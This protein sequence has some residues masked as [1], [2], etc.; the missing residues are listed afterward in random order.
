MVSADRTRAQLSV[1]RKTMTA[2]SSWLSGKPTLHE[3]SKLQ[4]LR[5][6][7]QELI[8]GARASRIITIHADGTEICTAQIPEIFPE[9]IP[10]DVQTGENTA[11]MFSIPRVIARLHSFCN[12]GLCMG[13]S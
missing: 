5:T 9:Q 3:N 10:Q 13:C 6:E 7:S 8:L 2:L 1:L 12:I 11:S 4:E